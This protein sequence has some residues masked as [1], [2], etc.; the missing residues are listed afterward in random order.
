MILNT[1]ISPALISFIPIFAE[2]YTTPEHAKEA[3]DHPWVCDFKVN[4][5]YGVISR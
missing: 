4:R 5:V 1:W 2:W 3:D